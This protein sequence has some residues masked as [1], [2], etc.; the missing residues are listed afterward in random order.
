MHSKLPSGR[1][2]R[3]ARRFPVYATLRVY[4]PDSITAVKAR[5]M[6]ISDTGA[7]VK[8]GVPLEYGSLVHLEIRRFRLY[9]TAYVVRCATKLAS[10]VAGLEFKGRLVGDGES[11]PG[12]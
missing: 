10:Y 8:S 9:G 1:D 2:R 6:N 12:F 7:A 3:T 5:I 4:R 11:L